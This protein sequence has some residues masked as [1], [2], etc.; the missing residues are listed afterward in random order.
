MSSHSAELH[1]WGLLV[2]EGGISA[3]IPVSRY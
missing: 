1:A 3:A 2:D